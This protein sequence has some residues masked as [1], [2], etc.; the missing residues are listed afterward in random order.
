[1]ALSKLSWQTNE[2]DRSNVSEDINEN[3]DTNEICTSTESENDIYSDT[4]SE[5]S[6]DGTVG[7]HSE[8]DDDNEEIDGPP[9]NSDGIRYIFDVPMYK[10]LNKSETVVGIMK[11]TQQRRKF[12]LEK[13]FHS[14]EYSGNTSHA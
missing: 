13:G 10:D 8:N 7:N 5:S 14:Q 2:A 12:V 9:Q 6:D 11:Y 4:E 3:D 1:M